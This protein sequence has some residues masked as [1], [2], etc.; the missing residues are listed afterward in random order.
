[1]CG[2]IAVVPGSHQGQAQKK[3]FFRRDLHKGLHVRGT[4]GR[5]SELI[6]KLLRQVKAA[7]S[8][9]IGECGKVLVIKIRQVLRLICT[10]E[11]I[12]H[13]VFCPCLLEATKHAIYRVVNGKEPKGSI[14][15]K[16]LHQAMSDYVYF[17]SV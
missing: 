7:W 8:T 12:F 1:M 6:K 17:S 3:K 4:S 14:P 16:A 9:S 15:S 10:H 13:L 11:R 5:K 2:P